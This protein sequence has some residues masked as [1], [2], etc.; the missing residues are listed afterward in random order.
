MTAHLFVWVFA[1]VARAQPVCPAV[2]VQQAPECPA[3]GDVEV[4]YDTQQAAGQLALCVQIRNFGSVPLDGWQLVWSLQNT[5]AF[6]AAE[7]SGAMLV[8]A[9]RWAL[10]L[11]FSV[12]SGRAGG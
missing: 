11:Q 4:R 8:N 3:A 10:T 6:T 2:A 5:T 12:A 7:V 1:W 9:G